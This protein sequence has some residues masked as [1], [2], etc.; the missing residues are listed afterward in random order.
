VA[1]RLDHGQLVPAVLPEHVRIQDAVLAGAGPE[2]DV[3]PEGEAPAV[4]SHRS[5]DPREDGDGARLPRPSRGTPYRGNVR[6]TPTRPGRIVL[7]RRGRLLR[8]GLIVVAILLVI[9]LLVFT[10]R[11]F[12]VGDDQ[13]GGPPE[14]TTGTASTPPPSV[15]S[16]EQRE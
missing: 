12:A 3:G 2:H 14:Q 5:R 6:P 10:V 13:A 1:T 8:S 11:S 4:V 7:T 9:V 16:D 15:R